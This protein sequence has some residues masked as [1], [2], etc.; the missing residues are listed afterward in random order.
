MSFV[1]I[2]TKLLFVVVVVA[3]CQIA[4]SFQLVF[5]HDRKLA[6][7]NAI[8]FTSEIFGKHARQ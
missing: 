3:K 8:H 1:Y 7:S 6:S 4:G 2:I 5:I